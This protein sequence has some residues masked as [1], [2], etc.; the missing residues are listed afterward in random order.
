MTCSKEKLEFATNE[1]NDWVIL[2]CNMLEKCK[3]LKNIMK[4]EL[5]ELGIEM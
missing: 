2:G 4:Q 5:R 3:N 1:I